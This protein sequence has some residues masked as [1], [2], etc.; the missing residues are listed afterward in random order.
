[1]SQAIIFGYLNNGIRNSMY[2]R[3]TRKHNYIHSLLSH[4]ELYEIIDIIEESRYKTEKQI[5]S[6]LYDKIKNKQITKKKFYI[7]FTYFSED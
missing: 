6:M 1:M 5:L 4:D 2:N 3:P 7:A